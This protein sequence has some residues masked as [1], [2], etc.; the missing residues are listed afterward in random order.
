MSHITEFSEKQKEKLKDAIKKYVDN[1]YGD[2]PLIS[3]HPLT[4]HGQLEIQR[5]FSID[6]TKAHELLSEIYP[7]GYRV[8]SQIDTIMP[9]PHDKKVKTINLS[10]YKNGRLHNDGDSP[11]L[12][13]YSDDNGDLHIR[14]KE[15]WKNGNRH[16]DGD[17]PAIIDYFRNKQVWFKN[18]YRYRD[19][20]K[21]EVIIGGDKEWLKGF[22]YGLSR[23]RGKLHR[24]GGPALVTKSGMKKWYFYGELHRDNGPAVE[25]LNG[26]LR[27]YRLGKLHR[28]DGPAIITGKGK[29]HYYVN[30]I[31]MSEGNHKA[32]RKRKGLK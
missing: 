11:A 26:G 17:K 12:I 15:W 16:R 22:G 30:G 23:T 5:I 31:E 13:G 10:C 4:S 18:G 19:G 28:L 2:S 20:D 7:E 32:F 8:L 3:Y 1:R 24:Q 9:G 14:T 21:P 25:H 29:K 27:Y 6:L